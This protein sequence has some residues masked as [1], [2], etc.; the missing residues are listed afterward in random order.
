MRI[1]PLGLAPQATRR[2]RSAADCGIVLDLHN[3]M[4]NERNGRQ[5]V[6]EVIEELPLD[7]VWEVHVAGGIEQAGYWLDAHS[8]EMCPELI[9]LC[10]EVV[11]RLTQLRA[12]IFELFPIFIP[13]M[14]LDRIAKQMEVLREIWIRRATTSTVSPVRLTPPPRSAHDEEG[15][16]PDVWETTLASRSRGG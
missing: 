2:R 10:H 1:G 9:E 11:P 7:R 13:R 8:G 16:S 15:P 6:L 14:G 12:L 4:A 3:L 5:P